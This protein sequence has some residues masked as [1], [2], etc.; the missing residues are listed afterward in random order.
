MNVELVELAAAALSDLLAEVV[1]VGGA[2]VEL[3]ITDPGAPPVRPTQDVDV[4][5][6]V[7]TRSAFHEFEAKLRAR[8]FTEDQEDGVICRWLHSKSGLILDAMPAHAG[9]LGFENPWQAEA[10]PT[11]S[12]VSFHRAPG[13]VRSRPRTCWPRSS[14]PSRD[15]DVATSSA[16]ET[17][18]TSW[19]S[20]TAA[21]S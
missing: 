4:I 6:E 14:R 5:V 12:S 1:F 9:I 11:P 10:L 3:W 21:P 2:T 7:T 15:A 20:S 18:P 17:S 19:R 16:A 13:S 8:G